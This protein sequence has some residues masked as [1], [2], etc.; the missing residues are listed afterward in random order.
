[1]SRQSLQAL[2]CLHVPDTNT[3]IKLWRQNQ[4]NGL[5]RTRTNQNQDQTG[6][7]PCLTSY[8]SR[9]HQVGL[10]V[11]VTAEHI[12][13]VTLQSLQT[14]PLE[15]HTEDTQSVQAQVPSSGPTFLVLGLTE[16]L[17]QIFRVLSSEAET[18]RL[19]SEDQE[20][21]EIPCTQKTEI[22]T[23]TSDPS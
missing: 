16:L 22:R 2:S 14:L 18:S 5:T 7:G 9:H 23:R 4:G 10:R 11:E 6:P 21:S 13:T 20:T 17:S 3:F 1:M 19:E 12:V 8:R 15:R